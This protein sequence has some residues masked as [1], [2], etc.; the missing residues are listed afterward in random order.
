MLININYMTYWASPSST[1]YTVTEVYKTS[2]PV[3]F[4]P[5]QHFR[6]D[7]SLY[8]GGNNA[9]DMYSKASSVGPTLFKTGF[10]MSLN[11]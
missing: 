9:Q 4:A 6:V 2:I 10:I 8:L 7:T 3:S 5:H 1:Q 11:Q